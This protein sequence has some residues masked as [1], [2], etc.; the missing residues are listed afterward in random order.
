MLFPLL[1]PIYLAGIRIFSVLFTPYPTAMIL[2]DVRLWLGVA[3]AFDAVFLAA[4]LVFFPFLYGG[5]Q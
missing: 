5:E 4:G 1:V 2:E 3:G